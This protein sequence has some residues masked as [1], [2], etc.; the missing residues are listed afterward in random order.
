MSLGG[1]LPAIGTPGKWRIERWRKAL[2][3][4]EAF[5]AEH[6]DDSDQAL[7]KASL[8]LRFR[9]KSGEPLEKIL[10]EAF[11]LVRVAAQRTVKMRHYDV[12]LLGGMGLFHGAIAEMDTGEG[13]TLTATLPLYLRAL[14]G[15]G[16]H[17]ATVNDYLAERDATEMGVIY[18][19]LGL[20]VGCVKSQDSQDQRREAYGADITYGTSKEFGFDFMRDR[21]LLRRMG[22]QVADFLGGGSTHRWDDSG[23]KPVQRRES[24]YALVDEADSVLI[25]EA[26]TPM[27]IGSLGD[28]ARDQVVATYRWA[29]EHAGAFA[30]DNHFEYDNEKKSVELTG[31]GRQLVRAL[32]Q[33][34]LLRSVGLVDLYQYMERSVKVKRDFH[35]DQQ[36]VIEEGEIVI[37]DEFTGRKAEG[38]KWRDGIHQA[39]EAKEEIEVTVP[40]G[41][42][43]RITVQDM[44]LRYKHLSGMTGTAQSA[45]REFRKIYKRPVVRIPTNRETKRDRLG[46]RIF[47]TEEAKWR[48]IVEEVCE[49]HRAGRPV[50]IGTKSIDKS[51]QLSELLRTRGVDHEVLNANE[52][53]KEA[54]IVERAGERARVTVATN[55]AG[56]GTDIKLAEGISE[57]G[58]L[59]VICTELHDSARVDRQLAGRCGRQGDPGTFRQYMSLDDEIVLSGYGPKAAKRYLGVGESS[60]EMS[61]DEWSSR[62]RRAQIKVER[63]HFRQRA[64]LLYH[65]KQRKKMQRE[66]GQDPYLDTPD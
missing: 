20:T 39:I 22:H 66:M 4:I 62:L 28:K 53:A 1:A 57:I 10:P 63:R 16:A 3:A 29:A 5:E 64:E 48:A 30:E 8:S 61:Y 26:R 56:R 24:H 9:V 37:V 59:H 38:R 17:L 31:P 60:P 40:T 65:E 50:L 33:P 2:P 45:A 52:I 42:A 7:R 41:Q 27:I 34:D 36:Y 58:G 46:D 25:D 55:M 21:L 35:L 23:E 47:G 15:K 18:T 49:L 44:F 14:E 51:E 13:K 12:Q 6:R 11:A 43:A 54:K 19:A 32:P